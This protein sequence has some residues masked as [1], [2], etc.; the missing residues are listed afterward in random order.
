MKQR[1][2]LRPLF[3][4]VWNELVR[5]FGSA[6]LEAWSA[7]VLELVHVNAGATCL[8]AFWDLSRTESKQNKIASLVIAA[9]SAADICRRAGAEAAIAALKTFPDA[10]R[11]L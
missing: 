11:L 6:D 9:E 3:Q 1:D 8:I 5:R 2:A 4:R 7:S 10:R